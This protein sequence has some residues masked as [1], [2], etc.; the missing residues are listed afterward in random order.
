M[1]IEYSTMK[2][3]GD[4]DKHSFGGAIGMGSRENQD[5]GT[6]KNEPREFFQG[7]GPSRGTRK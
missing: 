7:L 6:G 5:R 1:T 3:T 4:F 2:E